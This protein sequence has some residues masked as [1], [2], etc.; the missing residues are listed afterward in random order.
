MTTDVMKIIEA[1][2]N[3]LGMDVSYNNKG[4]LITYYKGK[5]QAAKKAVAAH[6]DTLGAMVKEI[7]ESGKLAITTI[8]GYMPQAVECENCL[9]HTSEGKTYSGTIYTTKPSVHVH[10]DAATA[11]RTIEGLEVVIDEKVLSSK[12]VIA[13]GIDV[14]D[15]ISFDS[16]FRVTDSG[17]V[18][19]RHLDDKASV[20]IILGVCK[21]MKENK[22][23]PKNDIQI[24]I[25]NHEEVGHGA[26]HG[27]DD[28]V[29]ELLCVD[30]GALGIG[31]NSDEYTVS[32]CAKDGGGPYD[33]ELRSRLVKLAKEVGAEYRIDIYPFY[34]SDGGTALKAGRNLKVALIGPG[35]YASH[36]YERTH[37]DSI[38]NTAKLLIAYMQQ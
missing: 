2:F 20:A 30:M 18:K 36:A 15:F 23:I 12:E 13:L 33:Y 29:A 17:Y 11:E 28:S 38:I 9:I 8:G 35:V 10:K 31:Q 16:R 3:K 32:I 26:S 25:T 5:T 21:Y 37:T 34:G 27:I 19:T 1:E 14:G 7:K 4:G 24:F 22:I 6:A